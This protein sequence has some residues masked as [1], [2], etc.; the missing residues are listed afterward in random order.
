MICK[1]CGKKLKKPDAEKCPH[2][3]KTLA[4]DYEGNGFYD[5]LTDG[6]VKSV[7]R[8]EYTEKKE[9]AGKNGSEKKVIYILSGATCIA[10]A[11][12]VCIFILMTIKIRGY[13][14]EIQKLKEYK[15]QVEYE[16]AVE[17]LLEEDEE[18]TETEDKETEEI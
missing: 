13:E 11:V 7:V 8:D 15:N 5:I 2:C 9:T 3:K 1:Y 12:A 16:K 6:V 10:A 17:E 18:I 14:D 4:S